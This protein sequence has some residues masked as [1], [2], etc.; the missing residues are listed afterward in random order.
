[1]ERLDR[2]VRNVQRAKPLISKPS[3]LKPQTFKPLYPQT[4]MAPY[5]TKPSICQTFIAYKTL[6]KIWQNVQ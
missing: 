4:F 1:M 3:I 2:W 6:Y 5:T